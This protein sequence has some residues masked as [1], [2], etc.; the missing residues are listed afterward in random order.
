MGSRSSAHG[1]VAFRDVNG[2]GILD[3]NVFRGSMAGLCAPL[4]T[5]RP[6]PRGARRMTRG[7]CGFATPSLCGTSTRNSLPVSRRTNTFR[8]HDRASYV[9]VCRWRDT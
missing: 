3:Y 4:S 2:V 6:A 8:L 1:R 7:Q 5:L 9:V